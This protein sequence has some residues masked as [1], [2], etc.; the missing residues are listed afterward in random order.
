FWGGVEGVHVLHVSGRLACPAVTI[1]LRAG[2]DIP[3]AG[4]YRGLVTIADKLAEI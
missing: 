4:G 2:T 3:E 1:C